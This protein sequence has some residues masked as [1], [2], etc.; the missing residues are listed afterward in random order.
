M[1]TLLG[2]LNRGQDRAMTAKLRPNLGL[3]RG[4]DGRTR[5]LRWLLLGALFVAAF[6]LGLVVAGVADGLPY[7][8]APPS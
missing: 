5:G 2:T 1:R 4:D 7:R 8:K 3:G 6:V